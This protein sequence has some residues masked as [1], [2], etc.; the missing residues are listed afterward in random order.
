MPMTKKVEQAMNAQLGFEFRSAYAYLA[1]SAWAE[2]ESLPG[3]AHWLRTQAT[4]EVE[5]AM[6]F[7]SY[8]IDRGGR[9]VLE[10]LGR[11]KETFS[12]PLEVFEESLANE[13][14]VTRAINELYTLTTKEQDYA[15]QAFLNWFVTEQ[16]EEEKMVSQ[17]IDSL[18]LAGHKGEALYMQDKDM[19]S[20]TP[21]SGA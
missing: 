9:V 10:D 4:E 11:P 6:K 20:R 15:S 12:S 1:M 8:V 5:H 2:S 18:K 13:Q 3:F 17:I 16:V 14:A 21:E 19:A 7:Y